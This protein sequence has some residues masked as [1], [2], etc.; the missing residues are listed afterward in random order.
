M[1]LRCPKGYRFHVVSTIAESSGYVSNVLPEDQTQ[2]WRIELRTSLDNEMIGYVDVAQT[3][4]GF[5]ETHSYLDAPH[6][7][8]GL[9]TLMYAKA[10]DTL[11][12]FG[13]DIRSSMTPSPNAEGCWRSKKLR[14][15]YVIKR[16][17]GRF[18]AISR[19]S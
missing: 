9:G 19:K 18:H 10:I 4:L 11:L 17:G 12:K 15:H 16:K 6:R 8:N 7:G 14:D 3:L 13:Q 2:T 1:S 5:W